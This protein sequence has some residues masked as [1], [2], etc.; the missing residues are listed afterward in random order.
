[1]EIQ[2]P[3]SDSSGRIDKR[4]FNGNAVPRVKGRCM[5]VGQKERWQSLELN[6]GNSPDQRVVVICGLGRAGQAW[7]VACST[8]PMGV[9]LLS[10]LASARV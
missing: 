4:K 7:L 1:V 3:H 8:C 2:T 10:D 5:K 9:V 6:F